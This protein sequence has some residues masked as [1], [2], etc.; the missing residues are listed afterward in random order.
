MLNHHFFGIA[1][2]T[3]SVIAFIPYIWA[4]FKKETKPSGASWWTW[5]FLNFI[6]F[7][8]GAYAGAPWQVLILP[9]WLCVSELGVAVLSITHGD[10]NWDIWNKLCV[11]GACIGIGLWFLTG[12]PIIA[13]IISIVADLFASIPNFRH[14]WDRPGEEDRLGWTLGWGSAVLEICAI[15][16]WSFAESGWAVYFLINMT[17]TLF[18]IYRHGFKKS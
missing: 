8:S 14:I 1:A 7:V 4:I 9:A 6:A 11:A 13:L 12:E 17:I 18:L 3:L 2:P 15:S 10:N 16:R 5:S